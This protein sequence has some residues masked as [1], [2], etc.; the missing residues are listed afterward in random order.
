MLRW[1]PFESVEEPFVADVAFVLMDSLS[2][3]VSLLDPVLPILILKISVLSDLSISSSFLSSLISD[4]DSDI[5]LRK[6]CRSL[7]SLDFC[8][9]PSL[10]EQAKEVTEII[11]LARILLS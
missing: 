1:N 3:K 9:S 7:S 4:L 6:R 8:L 5:C 2:N 10:I 11:S